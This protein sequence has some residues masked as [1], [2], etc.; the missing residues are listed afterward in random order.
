MQMEICPTAVVLKKSLSSGVQQEDGEGK[1]LPKN[2]CL[3]E[4]PSWPAACV[5]VEIDPD[6]TAIIFISKCNLIFNLLLKRVCSSQT[7]TDQC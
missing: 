3:P 4:C 6:D 5:N 1:L 7:S 2:F